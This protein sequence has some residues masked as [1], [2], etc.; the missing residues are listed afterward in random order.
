MNANSNHIAQ[1]NI[2][3]M[4]TPTIDDPIMATFVS[5]LNEINSLADITPGFVW[6]LKTESGDCISIR[7]YNDDRILVTL[8]VW[9]SIEAMFQFI[10]HSRH[11]DVMR[12]RKQ[13]FEHIEEPGL[14]LWWVPSGHIP[15]IGEAKERLEYLQSHGPTQYAFTFDTQFSPPE[16]RA[17]LAE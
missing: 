12:H 5:Q 2:A 6:R 14:V 16:I 13:W 15:T 4:L 1:F 11:S 7:P 10:Y 3:R 17:T 9:E 8:S